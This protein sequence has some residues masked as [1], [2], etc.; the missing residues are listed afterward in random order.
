MIP[1]VSLKNYHSEVDKSLLYI[2][3]TRAMHK[4]ILTFFGEQSS[5]IVRKT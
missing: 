5:L 1:G 4:L 3:C 2:A